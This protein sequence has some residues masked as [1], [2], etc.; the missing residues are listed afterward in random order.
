[1]PKYGHLQFRKHWDL[2]P[3]VFFKLGQCNAIIAAIA[4]MPVR[5]SHYSRLRQVALVKGAQAT[6]AIEG[7]TL[8]TEEVERV[9]EGDRLPPSKEYQET[10]V[11]NILE[12]MNNI[13]EEVVYEDQTQLIDEAL[14][15]RFHRMVGKDLGE[16]FDA[17]PGRLREDQRIVGSYRCPDYRDVP[18]LVGRLCA[19]LREEF[20]DES[21]D[22]TF[23]AA[24]VQA[25]VAHVYIEWI[26]PFGDGNGRTG[27]LVEFYIL[28]RAG[29][30]N[31]A[32]HVPSNFYNLTRSEYYRQLANASSTGDLSQFIAY[33]V[34]GFRDGLS[35][36]L[37]TIQDS[38]FAIAWRSYIHEKLAE[39]HFQRDVLKRRRTLAL[40]LPLNK[41]L[42]LEEATT[43]STRLAREYAML[44]ERTAAR[45]LQALEE[46]ELAVRKGDLFWANTAA[47]RMQMP[48]RRL[49][50]QVLSRV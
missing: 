2:T 32:S 43:V 39:T 25:I 34:Q 40:A 13:L 10:E 35:E 44:S 20:H 7:N 41:G 4:E 26:H 49:E 9:A 15:L 27:R 12:A 30:P 19:W 24:V 18:G 38:Q 16:H 14:L 46:L 47:L 28:L 37:E 29:L 42:T 45:D 33:A 22:Q 21:G 3:E 8:S 6:T 11:R 48:K 5:P 17:I 50:S 36:I 23:V 31:I 1:M